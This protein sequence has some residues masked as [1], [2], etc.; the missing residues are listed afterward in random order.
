[1][2]DADNA[3]EANC[4]TWRMRSIQ[5]EG[6]ETGTVVGSGWKQVRSGTPRK[7]VTET[8]PRFPRIVISLKCTRYWMEQ[9]KLAMQLDFQ[10]AENA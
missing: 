1:M 8:Q 7:L 10:E 3:N 2:P 9:C 6:V 4:S 5:K